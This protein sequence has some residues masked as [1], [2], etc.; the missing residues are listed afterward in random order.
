VF[1]AAARGRVPAEEVL[2][3]LRGEA[4]APEGPG[5]PGGPYLGLV[6]FEERDA[7]LFFGRDELADQ[8]VRRLAERPGGA[9][10]LLVAG[11]SGSGKSSLL[12]AG[13]LPRLAAGVLGPGSER[14]PRRVIR[15]TGSPLRELAM[16]LAEM[17][18]VDPVSVYRSLSAAPDKAPMLVEQAA[19]TATGRGP[20]PGSGGPAGATVGAPPRVVLVVD[21]FEELFT[22][23]EDGDVYTA[24]REAF[25]AALHAAAT[26]P[27]GP[28][29]LPTALVVAAVRAD[30]LGR[31]IAYPPLKA[32]LDA[33]LFTVGPMSEAELRLAVTG[34]AAEAGLVVEP[35]VVEAVVAEL[36]GEGG[37][38][39]GS[40]ILPLMSQA[41]AATWERREG[42]E[43]TLRGYRRAGGVA[44][45]VN[46]GAQA[47]YDALT[48]GQQD[49]ARLIFTQLTVLTPD[50]R[51]T[52]RRCRRADL[53][54]GATQIAADIDAVID[55]FS[56][57]RLLVLGE[58]SVE[59]AHDVLLQAWKQLRDWLGDDQLDRALYSQ[60]VIDAA[61]WESNGR[62]SAYLYRPGRLATIDA[63]AARWQGAPTRYPPLPATGEAFLGAAHH[64]TRRAVRRRRRVIA[65]LLALT[66]IA[67]SAAG[68]AVHDAA[69]A[70]RQAANAARQHAIALSRQ[71]A[72]E[73]L[74][75]GS[76]SPLTAR[77]L[78]VAAWRIFPT[79]QAGSALASLLMEQQQDGILPGNPSD[80][81]VNTV[82]FSPDRRLLAAAYGDGYV[83]LWNPVT[84][85]AAGSPLPVDTGPAGD[86]FGLAFSPDGKLL[87][88]GDAAGYLRLWNPAT[89]QAVGAPL[90]ADTS[91]VGGV[92]AVAFS[93]DGK[94]LASA[95]VDG[96][97]R[98]WNPATGQ[99]V[100]APLL[101]GSS[102]RG[103]GS[104][105][106]VAFSPDGKLLATAD[107]AGYVRLW[108]PA[109]GQAVGAPFLAAT[110]GGVNGV[111]FS[112][113][114]TLLASAGG[115]GTVRLR[116]PATRQ[117]PR[118]PLPPVIGGVDAVAFSPD[119]TLLASA[120]G[121]GDV[122]TW[123]LAN[124]RLA[125]V[126]PAE[127]GP[128]SSVDGVAF[129]P[130]GRLLA[131]ADGDGT[132]RLWNPA[133]GQA[134]GGFSGRNT[135]AFSPDGKVLAVPEFDGTVRTWDLATRQATGAP[136][137]VDLRGSVTGVAFSPDG[138]MLATANT[139]GYVPLW[140][141]ATRKPVGAPLPADP[142]DS[143]N[144]V[145]FSPDGRLLASADGDGTV[146]LWNRASGQAVGA[147]LV[148]ATSGGVNA[149]AFSPDGKLLA[150]AYSDGD[151][152]LWNPATGQAVAVPLPSGTGSG[153][154]VTGV[155]FSPDGKFLATADTDG[156]VRMWQMPLFTNP[157][158]ALCADVGPP[159]KAD[160][161]HYAPGEPQPN[162]CR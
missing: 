10:I 84:G 104:V 162:V 41:M 98:L 112:P 52:R 82:A 11:E 160:W 100:G 76:A 25:V 37:G 19:R 55:V 151:A 66:V 22:A 103:G 130:D 13:L 70:S 136:L 149:V 108:N 33:G 56:A 57:R 27:A 72:A 75:A 31:L 44:D 50:G 58:D 3:V 121:D 111:A 1:V 119:G 142:G 137:P 2:A 34:P 36:R 81:G 140:D 40:G 32:A 134:S 139:D 16:H 144:G 120:G 89:G 48:S 4:V 117:A 87:A 161:T 73:I 79:D 39:L 67:V 96:T 93:P 155:A 154:S 152:R 95:G 133:T 45:A 42:N 78:A 60:V 110:T 101:I 118:A 21:Q 116:N 35:A 114:G 62:D 106:G 138:T 68:I 12:R 158:A 97:V 126:I 9:G 69:D 5:W 105:N 51:F 54:S 47:A 102:P 124:Q 8:L 80:G 61:T 20:G 28:C 123:D 18:G 49:A 156:T 148:A 115:D 141:L 71:L 107:T 91:P 15:P 109:T 6:P 147:P 150:A 43:L 86:A 83:R 90:P 14:W 153:G 17:A 143:V 74:A 30:Y 145:A 157:Y 113:D 159:T 132:V 131:S 125:S 38:G 122:R 63:A 129:S 24:E 135:V 99:A 26:I 85:Q 94:L 92:N 65:G 7:Q 53:R 64:A 128:E 29:R 46:R 88:T 59:I 146:R 23:G 127:T 77:R